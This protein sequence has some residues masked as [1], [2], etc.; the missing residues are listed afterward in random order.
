MDQPASKTNTDRIEKQVFQRK[1]ARLQ[2][3]SSEGWGKRKED[4]M[5]NSAML[6]LNT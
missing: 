2:P 5:E 4:V 6:T 3:E 1:G